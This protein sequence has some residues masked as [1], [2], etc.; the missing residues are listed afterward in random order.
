MVKKVEL[1]LE[2]TQF[3][4]VLQLQTGMKTRLFLCFQKKL[5]TKYPNLKNNGRSSHGQAL[6]KPRR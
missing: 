4:L 5:L 3:S 6:S 2:L 1:K